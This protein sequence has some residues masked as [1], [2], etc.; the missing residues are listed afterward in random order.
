MLQFN[1]SLVYNVINLIVLC[2]LLKHFLIKPVLGIMDKRQAMINEGLENARSAQEEADTLKIQYEEAV[3]NARQESGR[4]V[5]EAKSRAKREYDR[6]VAEADRQASENLK[7][8]RENLEAEKD[9]AMADLK[10]R[11]AEVALF[12]AKKV[13]EGS[14]SVSGDLACYDRFIEEAGEDHEAD[15]R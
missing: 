2:F 15:S 12:A 3:K 7:K 5:E 1:V 6:I 10:G 4:I 13:S 8:S 14:G 11:I 9:K